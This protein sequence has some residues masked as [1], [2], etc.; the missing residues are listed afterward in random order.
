MNSRV[1]IHPKPGQLQ[2]ELIVP[3]PYFMAGNALPDSTWLAEF[4]LPDTGLWPFENI[5][6]DSK[7]SS[8]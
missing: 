2:G 7:F 5:Q 4:S 8:T 6:M 1:S 3:A